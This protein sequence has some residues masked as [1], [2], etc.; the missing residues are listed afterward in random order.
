LLDEITAL[1]GGRID[2]VP[3]TAASASPISYV[4]PDAPPHLLI[5]GDQDKIVPHRQSILYRDALQAAGVDV[6]L[7]TIE[8]VGHQGDVIYPN[9][10]VQRWVTEF[11]GRHLA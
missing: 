10:D 8:G 9:P 6:T 2:E 7:H 5:H 11:F 1:L 3:E 4:T